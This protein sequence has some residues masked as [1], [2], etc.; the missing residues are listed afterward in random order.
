MVG[1]CRRFW[2]WVEKRGLGIRAEEG[3]GV[4]VKKGEGEKV[5]RAREGEKQKK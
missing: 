1:K 4:Q 5:R 2:E 3:D